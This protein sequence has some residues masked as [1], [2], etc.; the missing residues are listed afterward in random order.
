MKPET[1]THKPLS[2]MQPAARGSWVQPC[3][4]PSSAPD[5]HETPRE[6]SAQEPVPL[7]PGECQSFLPRAALLP[8]P[9]GRLPGCTEPSLC[10]PLY[11]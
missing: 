11:I 6:P 10:R 9:L 1:L 4:P 8:P 2:G 5:T 3:S 7:S